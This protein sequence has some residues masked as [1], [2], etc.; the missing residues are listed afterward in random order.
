MSKEYLVDEQAIRFDHLTDAEL[1]A[2]FHSC[3]NDDAALAELILK[4]LKAR[5][6]THNGLRI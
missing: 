2:D 1:E 3:N 6:V 4:E 5:K